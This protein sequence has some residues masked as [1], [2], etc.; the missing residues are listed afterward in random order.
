MTALVVAFLT[1]LDPGA[2][3]DAGQEVQSYGVDIGLVRLSVTARD[4]SGALVHDL[5]RGGFQVL[6]DGVE[7]E[8]IPFGHHEAP[9]SVVVLLDKSGSMRDEK[10][11]HAKDAVASFVRAFRPQDEVLV[12][13]FSDSIDVL[14]GFGLDVRTIER[15]TKRIRPQSATRLYDA[16]VEASAAISD[17][18]RKEKRC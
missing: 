9:I 2:D 3:D 17:P 12:V 13:A 16:V 5:T 4:A 18:G 15:A 10:L 8:I 14:G 1:P 7:Q 11:M 6:E